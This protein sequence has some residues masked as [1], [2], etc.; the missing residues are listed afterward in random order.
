MKEIDTIQVQG[1]DYEIVDKQARKELE[2][3]AS[4]TELPTK[5]S[6]LTNDSGFITEKDIPEA[7]MSIPTIVFTDISQLAQEP[8]QEGSATYLTLIPNAEQRAILENDKNAIIKIDLSAFTSKY[9]DIAPYIWIKKNIQYIYSPITGINLTVNLYGFDV[10]DFNFDEITSGYIFMNRIGNGGVIYN[11]TPI[12]SI[13]SRTPHFLFVSFANF[14]IDKTLERITNLENSKPTEINIGNGI[15]SGSIVQKKSANEFTFTNP[16][17][18]RTEAQT[19]EAHGNS[20]CILNGFSR[21]ES[22]YAFAEGV[23]NIAKGYGSHAEGNRTIAKGTYTHAEGQGTCADGILSHAEGQDT[24]AKAEIT[25]AEGQLC[26]AGGYASHVEGISSKSSGECSHAEGRKTESS[27]KYSH[28]EGEHTEAKHVHSHAGGYYTTTGS[29][30]Q[31][32]IGQYNEI[33][34]D[35]YFIVGNGK[36]SGRSNAFRV[37]KDGR[38]YGGKS[39]ES[40][41]AGNVLV[42]KDYIELVLG[43]IEK[44]LGGI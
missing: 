13:L 44:L 18:S 40:N 2:D 34:E 29:E 43:D 36:S 7:D 26:I 30:K 32:V 9:P 27:G 3:K 42:T 1:E 22:S 4:K 33:I 21:T 5:T 16:Y 11:I 15:A 31:T 17:E 20:S 8:A 28:S 14:N 25:H 37:G 6:Q 38:V 12:P 41:D 24:H 39:T 19:V 10:P 23:N 35:A